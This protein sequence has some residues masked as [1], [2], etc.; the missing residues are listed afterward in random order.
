MELGK[1]QRVYTVEPI[2]LPVPEPAPAGERV[3]ETK[4]P[5]VAEA[6]PKR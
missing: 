3:A 1:I 4:R 6:G 5:K 2:V